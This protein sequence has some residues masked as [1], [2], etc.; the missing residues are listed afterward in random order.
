[1]TITHNVT[2]TGSD[3]G[4]QVSVTAW[5]A[6]HTI[7]SNTITLSMVAA[8]A[9]TEALI[10]ACSDE[11]TALAGTETAKF[12]LPYGFEVTKVKGSLNTTGASN[13]VCTVT[14]GGS[15]LATVTISGTTADDSS[16]TNTTGAENDVVSITIGAADAT[17]TGLKIYI[18]GYQV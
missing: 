3:S 5:N 13:V 14:R 1:M 6:N 2:A 11:S 17:A 9:K 4:D 15:A 12:V 16:P 10:I 7:G 18:I 8:A